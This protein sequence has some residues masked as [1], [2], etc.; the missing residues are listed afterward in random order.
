MFLLC[1]TSARLYFLIPIRLLLSVR[2]P[3]LS[4][5]VKT[6]IL[7]DSEA[8]ST[9]EKC[10]VCL[11]STVEV[12][13]GRLTAGTYKSPIWKGKSS[14]PN[15]HDFRFHGEIFQGVASSMVSRKHASFM[16]VFGIYVWTPGWFF[17]K[18]RIRIQSKWQHLQGY[19]LIHSKDWVNMCCIAYSLES[20]RP[21][22]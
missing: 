15:H 18:V 11:V 12:H 16:D 3:Q 7:G 2:Q 5:R 1:S 17:Y 10:W 13:P 9:V 4:Q 20:I 19:I 14:E 22:T 6:Q 8:S 21:L